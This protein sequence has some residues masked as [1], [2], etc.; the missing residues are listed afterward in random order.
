MT[1]EKGFGNLRVTEFQ[2]LLGDLRKDEISKLL[3][4]TQ[5]E[6]FVDSYTQNFNIIFKLSLERD[7]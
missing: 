6:S 3:S 5:R 1:E 2:F 4:S 7:I